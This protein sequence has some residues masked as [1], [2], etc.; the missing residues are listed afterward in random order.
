M[1]GLT[2]LFTGMASF[3]LVLAL[4]LQDGRGLGALASGV[5]FTAVAVPYMIGTRCR[6]G[7]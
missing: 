7:C 6:P 3:F 5:V 4:Y 1:L 2:V